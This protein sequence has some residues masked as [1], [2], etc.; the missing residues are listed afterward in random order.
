MTT[1]PMKSL[2]EH[3]LIIQRD[4]TILQIND[5]SVD[6]I[7]SGIKLGREQKCKLYKWSVLS[8]AMIAQTQI[9][10]QTRMFDN[11]SVAISD[12]LI[13]MK[14]AYQNQNQNR[15]F[16]QCFLIE[17]CSECKIITAALDSTNSLEQIKCCKNAVDVL[18]YCVEM[19]CNFENH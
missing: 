12:V 5:H 4:S 13:D 11:T 9:F 6:K 7:L 3:S 16:A 2:Q 18:V 8:Q 19:A 15:S 10:E 14:R 17:D 1:A